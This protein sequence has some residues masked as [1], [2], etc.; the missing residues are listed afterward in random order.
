MK[1]L[2][3]SYLFCIT[4]WTLLSSLS[5]TTVFSWQRLL[6]NSVKMLAIVWKSTQNERVIVN[7]SDK[8]CFTGG[9]NDNL[10]QYSFLENPMDSM[11]RQKCMTVEDEH[12]VRRCPICYWGTVK[13]IRNSFRKNVQLGKIV[14]DIHLWICLVVQ[15][16]T[17]L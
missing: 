13:A 10:L 12:A 2:L 15:V 14:N 1:V 17:M 4:I 9:G 16:S 8:M 5:C 11:K 6:S 3:S 7:I